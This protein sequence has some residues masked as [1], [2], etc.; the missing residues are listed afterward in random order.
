MKKLIARILE[1]DWN[2]TDESKTQDFQIEKVIKHPSY[3]TI[4][5]DNDI[6]L[7][8]LKDTIKFQDSMRPACLPEKGISYKVYTFLYTNNNKDFIERQCLFV[9]RSILNILDF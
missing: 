6:A 5:Y 3:S 8:K 1:H 7:L 4:N 9:K 2:S